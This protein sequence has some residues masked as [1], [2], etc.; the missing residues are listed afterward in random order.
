MEQTRKECLELLFSAKK[1]LENSKEK[2]DK[3]TLDYLSEA[4]KWLQNKNEI[5]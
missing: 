5:L 1:K 2:Q 3:Y 4:I